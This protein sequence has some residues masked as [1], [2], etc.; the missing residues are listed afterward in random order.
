MSRIFLIYKY[1]GIYFQFILF[2]RRSYRNGCE[3]FAQ[4]KNVFLIWKII[5]HYH[6]NGFEEDIYT[7]MYACM[8][9]IYIF[10]YPP[11][12]LPAST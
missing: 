4:Q 9:F 6:N 3:I 10:I 5:A 7:Y 2:Y 11:N 12:L 8:Y 1:I